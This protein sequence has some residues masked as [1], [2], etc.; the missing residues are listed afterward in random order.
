M[1]EPHVTGV[2]IDNEAGIRH[3]VRAALEADGMAVFPAGTGVSGLAD[4]ERRHPDFVIVDINVP[5]MDGLELIRE[6]RR[7][8]TALLVILSSRN[9]E[10]DKVA[11]LNAGADDYL[12]KPFGVPELVARIHAHLRR[13]AMGSLPSNGIVCFG[14]VEVDL[15]KRMVVREG[16]PVH[17]SRTEYRLLALLAQFPGQVLTREQLLAEI[18][19]PSRAMN[20]HYLRV[21]VAHLRQ[22][23]ERDPTHPKHIVTDAGGYRLD[24]PVC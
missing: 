12:T 15:G 7:T 6:I 19:G 4:I 20:H 5:D 23:L 8:S 10:T 1:N 11:A 14:G 24:V 9:R 18:W 22:K 17:L 21:Y 16:M 13:Q 3:F 2:V